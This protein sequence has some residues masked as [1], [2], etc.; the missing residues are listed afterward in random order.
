MRPGVGFP[1][2][3]FDR[4][5]DDDDALFYSW[6]RR[7]VHIDEGAIAALGRLYEEVVP[8]RGRVLD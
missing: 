1:P 7:V 3:A 5:D 8:P 4:L 6:P 2:G